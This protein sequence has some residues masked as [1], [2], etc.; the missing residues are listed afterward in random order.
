[1]VGRLLIANSPA[2]TAKAPVGVKDTKAS[3]NAVGVA[4]EA[5]GRAANAGTDTTAA[6][7]VVPPVA[8]VHQLQP[9][10][11]DRV[12][13][14]APTGERAAAR[15]RA[16]SN[17]SRARHVSTP[18]EANPETGTLR[19]NSRPWSQV[20]VDDN[21]VGNTPQANLQLNAGRHKIKLVNESMGYTRTFEITLKPGQTLTKVVNLIE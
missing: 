20:F 13:R 19:V 7:S 5:V 14:R 8:D 15:T 1:M 3:N 4:V 21:L 10:P 11:P 12:T 9:P 16:T 17:A 2:N 6:S 18:T